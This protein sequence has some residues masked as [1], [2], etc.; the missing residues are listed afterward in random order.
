MTG[1]CASCGK[2]RP[3]PSRNLCK[4]C[5]R[6]HAN[7]GSRD[8]FPRVYRTAAEVVEYADMMTSLGFTQAQVASDLGYASVNSLHQV[9]SRARRRKVKA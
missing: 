7:A 4:G 6:H 5:E 9:L 3:L 2:D 1:G 8:E